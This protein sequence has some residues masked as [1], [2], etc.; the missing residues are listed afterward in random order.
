MKKIKGHFCSPSNPSHQT[1]PV[2]LAVMCEH[3]TP[4]GVCQV[5]S[6]IKYGNGQHLN[7]SNFLK[8]IP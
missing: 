3:W 1:R 8:E 4:K 6:D 5:T 7:H 2:D